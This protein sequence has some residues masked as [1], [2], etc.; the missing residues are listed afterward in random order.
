MPT[1]NNSK[2]IVDAMM[3]SIRPVIEQTQ[4]DVHRLAVEVND[5]RIE[6][7]QRLSLLKHSANRLRQLADS[8][9]QADRE[10]TKEGKR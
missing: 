3:E 7:R 5:L 1:E 8:L 9:E 6:V 2:Q 4:D 10:M